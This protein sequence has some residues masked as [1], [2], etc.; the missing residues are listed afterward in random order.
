L[1][2]GTNAMPDQQREK[3]GLAGA[4]RILIVSAVRT[5][6]TFKGLVGQ[7]GFY[8][9]LGFLVLI[10]FLK[11]IFKQMDYAYPTFMI[12]EVGKGVPLGR[13]SGINNLA[14]ILLVPVVGAL[15]QRFRAYSMVIFGG[16]I[17]ALSVFIMT[18]P[19]SWFNGLAN[20]LLGRCLGHGYLGLSGP[21][22]PYYV[23]IFLFIIVLSL[24]ESFYSPRV[25]EYAAAIAPKG[26]EASYSALSYIP[27]ILPKLMVGTISGFLLAK[28]CPAEGP[29]RPELMWLVIALLTTVA[30]IGLIAFRRFLRVSEAGRE[31]EG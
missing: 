17:C 28:Y 18:L 9:L 2:R 12:R 20:G 7:Q 8:R 30:P 5:F 11:L 27:F 19:L 16:S 23:M 1:D 25:Y 4:V 24:G 3:S 15:T 22:H 14:I 10:A 21:V 31:T 6:N 29:R 26:Q 13:L